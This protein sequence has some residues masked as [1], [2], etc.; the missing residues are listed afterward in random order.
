M[1]D[2]P[3]NLTDPPELARAARG[4]VRLIGVV[5]ARLAR[6]F[7]RE[8]VPRGAGAALLLF[9]LDAA[10]ARDYRNVAVDLPA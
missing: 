7:K 8:F 4:A 10:W 2:P 1:T 9:K 5:W 3:E 6:H